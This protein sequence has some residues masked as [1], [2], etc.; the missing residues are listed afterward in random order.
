[1]KLNDGQKLLLAVGWVQQKAILEFQKYPDVIGF[2]V[3][4]GT[5]QEKRPL[6]KATLINSSKKNVPF[7]NAILPSQCRWVF[8]WIFNSAFPNLLPAD[9]LKK[10]QLVITDEDQNCFNMLESARTHFPRHKHRICKW[11]KVSY[12]LKLKISN[13]YILNC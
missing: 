11:H 3:T 10:V 2:D 13:E 6:A 9:C 1:M 4:Y 8:H 5:N 12:L 7:F